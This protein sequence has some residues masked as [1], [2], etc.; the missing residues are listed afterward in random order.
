VARSEEPGEELRERKRLRDEQSPPAVVAPL[1]SF[2]SRRRAGLAAW[3]GF[4]LILA[5]FLKIKLRG[6]EGGAFQAPVIFDVQ[7][8]RVSTECQRPE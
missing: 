2:E 1:A 6:T 8:T 7:A 3:V 4:I 5:P